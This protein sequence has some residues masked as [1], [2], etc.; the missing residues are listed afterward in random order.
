[1]DL[2]A[3]LRGCGVVGV[4]CCDTSVGEV[5]GIQGGVLTTVG[6]VMVTMR[7][8]NYSMRSYRSETRHES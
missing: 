4:G 1:M 5:D 3:L 2:E 7:E 6:M 8:G